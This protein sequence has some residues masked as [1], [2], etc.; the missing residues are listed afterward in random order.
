MQ[1]DIRMPD[2]RMYGGVGWVRA[3]KR[4]RKHGWLQCRTMLANAHPQQCTCSVCKITPRQGPRESPGLFVFNTCRHWRRT[5][6]VLPRYEKDLD[7]L[8]SDSEDHIADEMRY[9]VRNNGRMITCGRAD[10]MY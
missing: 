5:V 8:D 1:E 7:D 10:G 3:D 6:P 2:G 4:D 9:R